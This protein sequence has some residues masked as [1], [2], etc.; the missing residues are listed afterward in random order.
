[1]DANGVVI[2][3]VLSAHEWWGPIPQREGKDA[4]QITSSIS[5]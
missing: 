1:M 4:I 2:D 3:S 5:V